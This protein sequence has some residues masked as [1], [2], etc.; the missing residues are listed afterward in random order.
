[1]RSTIDV[2]WHYVS[3]LK[4]KKLIQSRHALALFRTQQCTG[5]SKKSVC[6]DSLFRLFVHQTW[7]TERIK[8]KTTYS[9]TNFLILRRNLCMW[10]MGF[11]R[12][13]AVIIYWCG[14]IGPLQSGLHAIIY[15]NLKNKFLTRSRVERI[16]SFF[17]N[18]Y[19]LFSQHCCRQKKLILG[20]YLDTVIVIYFFKFTRVIE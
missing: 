8:L 15:Q 4:L 20:R 7:T 10:R 13:H 14:W 2:I 17:L 1:M 16:V 11:A 12:K 18:R 6:I 19:F 3:T 9:F 5:L